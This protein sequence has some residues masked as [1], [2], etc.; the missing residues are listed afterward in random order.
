MKQIPVRDAVGT[1]ICHDMTQIIP[2]KFKGRRF[3]KGDII[4]KEDIPVLISMGR[5]HIYVWEDKEGF[6]HE[7]EAAARLEKIVA[8]EGLNTGPIKEGKVVFSADYDGLLKV[9]TELLLAINMLGKVIVSTVHN[10]FPVKKGQEVG[11]TRAI[12]LLIDGDVIKKAEET[13]GQRK[14]MQLLPYKRLKVGLVTTGNEV[15]TGIVKDRFGPLLRG[16]IESFGSEL[17]GQTIVPDHEDRIVAAIK[18]YLAMGADMIFCTGGMSVDPDDLTPS[19]IEKAGGKIVS[20][21]APILPGATFLLAYHGRVPI[22]GLPGGMIFFKSSVFDIFLPRL[23]VQ[24]TITAEDIAM[25][26][27]GGF[28][29]GCSSCVYPACSFGKGCF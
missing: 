26:G 1:V 27:H 29:L 7:D 2:G 22:L 3:K 20:H 16:K 15:F 11:A 19:A 14:I 8:G 4:R 21:G 24:E 17:L 23:L 9:D 12:P 6:L 10:N 13:A 28:C 18:K 25:H 5:E